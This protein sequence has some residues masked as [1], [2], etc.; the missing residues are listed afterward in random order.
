M[1]VAYIGIGSNL[2]DKAARCREAAERMGRIPG[3]RVQAVSGLYRTEPVGVTE[4]DWFLNGVA[5]LETD[6]EAGE[7]LNRLLAVERD[8]GRVRCGKWGPR[9]I[10]LDVLLFGSDILDLVELKVPHPHMHLRRFVLVPMVELAPD[11]RHPVQGK[12][13]SELLCGV[14]HDGQRVTSIERK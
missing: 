8:M 14:S 5:A 4:Q 12:T 3:C 10:D 11:L 1:T 9:T 2:G 6:L 13:M 7:L